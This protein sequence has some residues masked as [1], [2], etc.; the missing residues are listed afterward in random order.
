MNYNQVYFHLRGIGLTPFQANRL[1]D[2]HLKGKHG[3]QSVKMK[4]FNFDHTILNTPIKERI[5]PYEHE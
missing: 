4:H 1:C 5:P 3:F 2:T